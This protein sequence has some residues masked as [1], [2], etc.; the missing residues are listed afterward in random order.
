MFLLHQIKKKQTYIKKGL[1]NIF[2]SLK[3]WKYYIYKTRI[4]MTSWP[5]N[6][7][8][9][10]PKSGYVLKKIKGVIDMAWLIQ[11][12]GLIWLKPSLKPVDF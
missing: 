9:P 12:P 11:K 2:L 4:S 8:D 1:N 5:R 3:D 7:V 10:R 6:P